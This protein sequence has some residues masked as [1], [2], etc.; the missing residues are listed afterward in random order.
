MEASCGLGNAMTTIE[1]PN[2]VLI[3]FDSLYAGAVKDHADKLPSLTALLG[4]SI[5]YDQAFAVAPES[6][7]ARA[8]LFTG[9]DMAAHGVWTD[10]VTLPKRETTLPEVFKR[11]GYDTWLVGRRQLAG[12]SHWTTEHARAQEY[13]HFDWAHGPLHR[14]RQNAY[15]AWLKAQASD[16]YDT[17]F[18]AQASPDDTVI[19]KCQ[20]KA[21][22][23]LPDTLSFNTWLGFQF[24][25]RLKAQREGPFFGIASFVVG[26]TGGAPDGGDVC[27]EEL[28][29][30]ALEHADGAIGAILNGVSDDTIVVVT[31][32]RG[33][34]GG[35]HVPLFIRMP[36]QSA[37]RVDG[38]VSTM[39][40]A[41]TL[42]DAAQIV[43]PQRIQGRC[44]LS[45]PPRGWAL[46]RSRHPDLPQKTELRAEDW[47][48]IATQRQGNMSYELYDLNADPNA[49]D[50][51]ANGPHY[52]E[53]LEHM[54]DLLIDSRV[55]L[56]DRTEPR[57][58]KF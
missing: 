54:I 36:R 14:S 53:A 46:I 56:E 51:L 48:I 27:H 55:A 43:R 39:D 7:P 3:L 28:D 25:T 37:K 2:I 26:A 50:N 35:T 41:P 40:I 49:V 11:N 6:G 24:C 12:V 5:T 52:G 34:D 30:R 38:I 15:L 13:V 45:D 23:D 42:Y 9:L 4:Q 16:R 58:A 44:L 18:P 19:P 57:I 47:K 17:I 21:M 22:A 10:G 29:S 32:G 20:R 33:T 8:S 31:A 1:H